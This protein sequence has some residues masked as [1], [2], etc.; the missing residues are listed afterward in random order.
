MKFVSSIQIWKRLQKNELSCERNYQKLLAK[1]PGLQYIS[2]YLVFEI[3]KRC[4][5]L[6]MLSIGYC[7]TSYLFYIFS[8]LQVCDTHIF[9]CLI[10]I[11]IQWK[12]GFA[13]FPRSKSNNILVGSKPELRGSSKIFK[14]L[15]CAGAALFSPIMKPGLRIMDNP[16]G[17]YL[18][19]S[20]FN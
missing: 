8:P 20:P 14:I 4:S 7:S 2:R 16:Q 11:P 10:S 19:D 1:G 18:A 5:L 13:M 9:M 15:L 6:L 17:L 3:R 12:E